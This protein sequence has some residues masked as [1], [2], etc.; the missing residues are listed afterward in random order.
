MNPPPWPPYSNIEIA[1]KV[2]KLDWT[3]TVTRLGPM[4]TMTL[5]AAG[6]AAIAALGFLAVPALTQAPRSGNPPAVKLAPP[7]TKALPAPLL[8]EGQAPSSM[9]QVQLT[10]APVVKRV[11]PAVVNVYARTVVQQ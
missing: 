2:I 4:K 6:V 3:K 7:S 10:F 8:P 11:I 9:G 5:A 1:P